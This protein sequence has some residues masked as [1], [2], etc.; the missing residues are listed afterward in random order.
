MFH[1]KLCIACRGSTDDHRGRHAH[2]RASSADRK[3]TRADRRLS[4]SEGITLV[5]DRSRVIS[6]WIRSIAREI[7]SIRAPG[8]STGDRL[9]VIGDR[10]TS[11]DPYLTAIGELTGPINDRDR[12]IRHHLDAIRAKF[13][14]IDA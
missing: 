7:A 14:A 3:V 6:V 9:A 4:R 5:V 2:C 1:S 8:G 11:I 12:V 10:R 13:N